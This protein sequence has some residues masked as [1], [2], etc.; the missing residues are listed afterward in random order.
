MTAKAGS[1]EVESGGSISGAVPSETVDPADDAGAE[2]VE[3]AR[4]PSRRMRSRV[5]CEAEAQNSGGTSPAYEPHQTIGCNDGKRRCRTHVPMKYVDATAA[6][7]LD[8]KRG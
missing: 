2:E 8:Y 1:P 4:V 5:D 3:S 6:P 7:A